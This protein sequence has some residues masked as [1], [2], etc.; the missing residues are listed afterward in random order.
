M[1]TAGEVCKRYAMPIQQESSFVVVGGHS[2][3]RSRCSAIPLPEG[4][5][6]LHGQVAA[7]DVCLDRLDRLDRLGC[8][9]LR[10]D[11]RQR[12]ASLPSV[13]LRAPDPGIA[14]LLL[15]P[16]RFPLHVI[17]RS[18]ELVAVHGAQPSR[19]SKPS[20][21]SDSVISTTAFDSIAAGNRAPAKP[22]SMKTTI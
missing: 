6:V 21:S 10:G 16:E 3:S 20:R 1:Q 8:L 11:H 5:R 4:H 9:V 13:P 19:S 7:A 14:L 2:A 22:F 17:E 12:L 15:Q 18:D